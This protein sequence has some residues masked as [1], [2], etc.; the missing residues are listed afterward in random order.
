MLD[1]FETF[2]YDGD[3]DVLMKHSCICKGA[4]VFLY[5]K[6][7][8]TFFCRIVCCAAWH[9]DCDHKKICIQT[10]RRCFFHTVV[11][12]CWRSEKTR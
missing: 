2:A 1:F 8:I 12:H 7:H 11:I 9:C 10:T 6:Q 5:I 3:E 4:C